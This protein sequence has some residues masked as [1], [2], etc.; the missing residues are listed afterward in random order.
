MPQT[1]AKSHKS[2]L[3][4]TQLTR[5]L[6][7]SHLSELPIERAFKRLPPTEQTGYN[8]FK[9]KWLAMHGK[10]RTTEKSFKK[11]QNEKE[12]GMLATTD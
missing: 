2:K 7:L 3:F 5:N 9:K 8:D 1:T 10:T 6:L 11:A 12:D 4:H